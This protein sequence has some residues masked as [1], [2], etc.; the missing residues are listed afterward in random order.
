MVRCPKPNLE[1]VSSR[2]ADMCKQLKPLHAEIAR[3]MALNLWQVDQACSFRNGWA[4][5][6][7]IDCFRLW[8]QARLHQRKVRREKSI[9]GIAKRFGVMEATLA[10]WR[11]KGPPIEG[12][13]KLPHCLA[14]RRR[15]AQD[16]A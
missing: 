4:P 12:D 1:F 11:K 6:A 7:S 13:A 16:R 5:D 10:A 8:W 9:R 2:H 14:S 15:A 3:V